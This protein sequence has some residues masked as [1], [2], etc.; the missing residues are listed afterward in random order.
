MSKQSRKQN[1]PAFKAKVALEAIR[2]VATMV[3]MRKFK[4]WLDAQ[5]E[6]PPKSALG[7]A[8]AYT[9]NRWEDLCVFL[10]DARIPLDNNASERALRKVALGRKNWMFVGNADAGESYATLMT[11]VTS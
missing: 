7:E 4:Q 1:S 8:I 3:V 11:V 5:S 9:L 2:E 10:T 6:I